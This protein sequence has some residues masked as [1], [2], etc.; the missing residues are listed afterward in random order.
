MHTYITQTT[1]LALCYS[2]FILSKGHPQG[3]RPTN[4]HSQVN[5]IC[6]RCKIKLIEQ[7]VLCYGG[8]EIYQLQNSR[9]VHYGL[10][11]VKT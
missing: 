2:M 5:K 8:R 6:S 3:V 11:A 1:L 4:F 7:R 9:R 10:W